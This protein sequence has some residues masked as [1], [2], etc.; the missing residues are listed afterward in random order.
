MHLVHPLLGCLVLS[1]VVQQWVGLVELVAMARR[2]AAAAQGPQVLVHL[3]LLA[4]RV[5]THLLDLVPVVP[6]AVTMVVAMMVERAGQ[7]VCCCFGISDNLI[8][9]WAVTA[10]TSES[11]TLLTSAS[12]VACLSL[13]SIFSMPLMM[14]GTCSRLS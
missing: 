4:R 3:V 6:V 14:S 7:A 12:I 8:N 5:M 10:H 2:A 1:P 13:G 9:S 11:R